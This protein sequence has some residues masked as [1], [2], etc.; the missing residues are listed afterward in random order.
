MFEMFRL[1][2]SKQ[3]KVALLKRLHQAYSKGELRLI[4]RIHVLLYLLDGKSINE[5]IEVL[6]LSRQSVY[7]YVKAFLRKGFDSLVYQRPPGRPRK[8]TKTQRKELSTLI[9][10]GPE[11]AGYDYGAWTTGLIQDLIKKRFGVAYSPHYVAELLRNMGYSYQRARFVS[12]HIEDVAQ[13]RTTW[14]QETWPEILRLAQE[15]GSMILFGD[16]ASFAQ[17]GSL[18][19]TWS[20]RGEQPT[21]KTSGKRKAYKVMGL[22]DYFSGQFFYT[23]HTGRFNSKVYELFLTEVLKEA[24]QHIIIVQDGASYHTSK[25][26]Q[27]FF[28]AHDKELAV[29]QLPRYSPEFNPIE[30]LWRNVKKHATHLRYFPKFEDLTQKVDQKLQY[31]ATLPASILGLM[32]RYCETLGDTI[33]PDTLV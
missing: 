24:A 19:Y 18:S 33:S 27:T 31:F 2:I 28:A 16:E 10:E 20:R 5:I 9:D 23:T 21:V 14:M 30:F 4:K 7:N 29:Y 25:A 17:W 13:E 12:G 22:I 15:K 3:K 1:K 8:L 6:G 11:A 26:M 32:G